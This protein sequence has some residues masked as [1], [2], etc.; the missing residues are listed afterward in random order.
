MKTNTRIF[1]MS[2]QRHLDDLERKE[3]AFDEFLTD[4]LTVELDNI[5]EVYARARA[6]RTQFFQ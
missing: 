2:E 4:I 1:N 3:L 5:H 6:L